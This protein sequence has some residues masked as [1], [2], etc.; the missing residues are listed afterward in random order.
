MEAR[1]LI[2]RVGVLGIL[3][4]GQ[5]ELGQSIV[6]AAE[7]L[8]GDGVVVVAARVRVGG[9]EFLLKAFR[10]FLELVEAEIGSPQIEAD[11]DRKSV[12]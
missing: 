2:E 6:S 4:Q 10:R 8:E 9:R 3:S 1:E 12:V 5:M 11:L 7:R